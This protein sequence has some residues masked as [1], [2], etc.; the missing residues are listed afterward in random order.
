MGNRKRIGL[1]PILDIKNKNDF[2]DIYA[3]CNALGNEKRL[4]ILKALNV[5]P[6][7]FSV[8][9]LSKE[10]K[11]PV[12]TLMHH[13][14]ILEKAYLVGYEYHSSPKGDIRMYRRGMQAVTLSLY[15]SE[16]E[17]K[18][19]LSTSIQ[20]LKVGMFADFYGD[21]LNLVTRENVYYTR[22]G[23]CFIPQRYDAELVFSPMGVIE[24]Y[25]DNSVA[26][27]SKITELLL[28]FELCSEAPFYD[29]NY[30]SSVTFWIND[31]R[32]ATHT[33]TGDY[34]DRPGKLN[35]EWWAKLKNTQHGQ[36]LTISVN[37]SGV[38]INGTLVNKMIGINELNLQ[39]GNK[40][41]FKFGNEDTATHPGGFNLF[42]SGF[43]DY[44][45]DIVLQLTYESQ[46]GA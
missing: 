18:K 30:K 21:A 28:S 5:P 43:G 9:Q 19:E 1:T 35:P 37:A 20:N 38:S 25:F 46:T 6:Y 31:V 27:K 13:L 17:K 40:I 15:N 45:Q 16:R 29:A 36:M 3:I 24:Y 4:G 34:G 2:N 10:L 14:N 22:D 7:V 11:L 12:S 32:L 23:N 44:E 8:S 41:A 33:L 26:K 42:G 39:S